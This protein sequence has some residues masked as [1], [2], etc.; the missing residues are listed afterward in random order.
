[1]RKYP[2][3]SSM[4]VLIFGI[5]LTLAVS[6]VVAFLVQG[7]YHLEAIVRERTTALTTTNDRFN[8]MAEHGRSITWKST[9][10]GSIPM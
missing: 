4:N 8:Q 10:Q 7:R 1:M 5:M 6:M 9:R 3:R 2:V